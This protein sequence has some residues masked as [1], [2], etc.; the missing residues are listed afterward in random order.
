VPEVLD[1]EDEEGQRDEHA[2]HPH[3]P[4]PP[5]AL[6]ERAA[7]EDQGSPAEGHLAE[8]DRPDDPVAGPAHRPGKMD[9]RDEEKHHETEHQGGPPHSDVGGDAEGRGDQRTAHEAGPEHPPRHV[10]RHDAHDEVR[11]R[12][13]ERPEDGQRN[14][15]AERSQG[16]DPMEAAGRRDLAPR[17]YQADH[18]R[19]GSGGAHREGGT[20]HAWIMTS[21]P[22]LGLPRLI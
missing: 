20:G 17:G 22:R 10:G 13:M 7:R 8:D 3:E 12:E 15:E 9:H 1:P 14:G 16:H 2:P 19:R 5:C 21:P 11:A 4:A 18:E 6:P